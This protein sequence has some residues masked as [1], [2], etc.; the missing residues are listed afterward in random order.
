M[1]AVSF[2][3]T[4]HISEVKMTVTYKI[5]KKDLYNGD[6]SEMTRCVIKG[7]EDYTNILNMLI[8]TIQEMLC[9]KNSKARRKSNDTRN[10][11]Q[12]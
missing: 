12:K 7:D 11:K 1:G 8:Q 5:K 9:E 4:F 3:G 6:I 2:D 10:R